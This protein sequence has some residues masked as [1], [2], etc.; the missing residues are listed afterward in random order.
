MTHDILPAFHVM[1]KPTGPRCN[2]GP[3]TGPATGTLFLN[4]LTSI[5]LYQAGL[6]NGLPEPRLT[7]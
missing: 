2:M 3:A 5:S 7:C 6:R 4:E 1:A